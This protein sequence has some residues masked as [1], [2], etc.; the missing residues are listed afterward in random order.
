MSKKNKKSKTREVPSKNNVI[1]MILGVVGGITIKHYKHKDKYDTIAFP[2]VNE[3]LT[4][5]ETDTT[6]PAETTN[7][8]IKNNKELDDKESYDK[9]KYPNIINSTKEMA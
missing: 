2:S 9:E 4:S 3:E 7:T 1:I 6:I 5:E 8:N